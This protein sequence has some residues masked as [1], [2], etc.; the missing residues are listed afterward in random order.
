VDH[1]EVWISDAAGIT[2]SD[3]TLVPFTP[4]AVYKPI[5]GPP[6][7][8][9]ASPASSPEYTIYRTQRVGLS[10]G[11]NDLFAVNATT[12][13][14]RTHK[15]LIRAVDIHGNTGPF[16]NEEEFRGA[17]QKIM[18]TP[19]VAWPARDLPVPTNRVYSPAIRLINLN[20][21]CYDG[22]GIVVGQAAQEGSTGW[23]NLQLIPSQTELATD[24]RGSNFMPVVAY[25]QQVSNIFFPTVS[26]DVVQVSPLIEEI[27][28]EPLGGN[29][30]RLADPFFTVLPN[31]TQVWDL[32]LKDTQPVVVGARYRYVFV[33]FKENYELEEV[34]PLGEVEVTP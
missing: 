27:A 30:E 18:L 7:P 4:I 8:I 6:S 19:Q 29:L 31:A 13:A 25:R 12:V 1:F 16:S 20:G 24:L 26:G 23:S 15:I 17:L 22:I 34:V 2:S 9:P 21:E 33:R 11:S 28:M 14:G 5:L 32:V 3:L 10:F